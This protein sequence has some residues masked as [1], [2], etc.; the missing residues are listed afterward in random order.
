MKCFH[1]WVRDRETLIDEQLHEELLEGFQDWQEATGGW[2]GVGRSFDGVEPST[3]S[4]PRRFVMSAPQQK[5]FDSIVDRIL[6]KYDKEK[7]TYF[8]SREDKI[9]RIAQATRNAM[10]HER[11]ILAPPHHEVLRGP[12]RKK[13]GSMIQELDQ[14]GVE[15]SL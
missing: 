4:A 12:V 3:A 5:L 10:K 11:P 7:L 6:G 13:I 1:E 9:D 8:G 2:S 15:E 14:P